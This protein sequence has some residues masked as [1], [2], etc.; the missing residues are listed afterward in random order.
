MILVPAGA[1]AEAQ[2]LAPWYLLVLVVLSALGRIA[3]ASILYWLADKFE[4]RLLTSPGRRFFGISH[5]Q[6]EQF[7][8]RLGR[9]GHRDWIVLFLMNALPIFPAA[10]LSLA[11]GFVKVHFRMF[12]ACTFFGTMV[13]ALIYLAIGYAGFRTAEA[14]RNIEIATQ[15]V[16]V[17]LLVAIVAWVIRKRRKQ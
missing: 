11:C 5:K 6:I 13:N 15:V 10:V 17:V 8:Q 1:A 9:A 7:G 16:M 12:L 2:G 4:D 3:G 14:L